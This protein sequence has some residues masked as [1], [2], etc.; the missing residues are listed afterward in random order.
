MWTI[1]ESGSNYWLKIGGEWAFVVEIHSSEAEGFPLAEVV[2]TADSVAKVRC[3]GLNLGSIAECREMASVLNYAAAIA[4]NI[5]A[6]KELLKEGEKPIDAY[7]Q[8]LANAIAI[9]MSLLPPEL[10]D[11]EKIQIVIAKVA[12]LITQLAKE[13]YMKAVKS[14]SAVRSVVTAAQW[15]YYQPAV[16]DEIGVHLTK[17]TMMAI[18]GEVNI[19]WSVD[20]KDNLATVVMEGIEAALKA[21]GVK[22]G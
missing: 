7:T 19:D 13:S 17:A 4:A 8:A 11:N 21:R 12:E 2:Q 5:E 14:T 6:Y 18:A 15:L 1:K 20:T 16:S 3:S 9:E 10:P 22:V